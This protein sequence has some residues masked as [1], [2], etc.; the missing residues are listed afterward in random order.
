MER[1]LGKIRND[2]N[3]KDLVRHSGLLYISGLFS[4]GFMFAQQMTTASLLGATDFGRLAVVLSTGLTV[5]TLLDFRT[6]EIGSKLLTEALQSQQ[7]RETVRI[8]TWLYLVDFFAGLIG[9]A[10]LFVLAE[11]VAIS[12]LH[13]PELVWLIRLY[14]LSVPFRLLGGGIVGALP[15]YFN[16]FDWLAI[17]AVIYAVVRLVLMTGAALLGFGFTGVV[18]AA[19]LSEIVH[20]GMLLIMARAIWWNR[21]RQSAIFDLGKPT[22]FDEG[23]RMLPRFWI[24]STL[25]GLHLNLFIPIA[26][27]LTTPAQIGV[28][29]VGVAVMEL[30][31]RAIQPLWVVFTPKIIM[32]YRPS[33]LPDFRKYL[34]QAAGVS[35]V[36]VISLTLMLIIAA[37]FVLPVLLRGSEY[38]G[39][40]I[41]TIILAA[42][43]GVYMGLMWTRPA[44]ITTGLISWH[45]VLTF[46]LLILSLV[47]LVSFVPSNGAVGAAVAKAVFLAL[48]GI[49]SLL[50]LRSRVQL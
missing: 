46:A 38:E 45:N 32:L 35:G 18:I 28:F 48:S 36:V 4:L 16:H 29:S 12:L 7:H 11:F 1:I 37:P 39:V 47:V 34:R 10:L 23:R 14:A 5:A 33:T 22:N 43:N 42:A 15:R 2:A 20:V 24:N 3:L 6:W 49:G 41:V 8:I 13:D 25:I 19:L 9:V 21:L 50:L 17:K 31:D 40:V 26:A 44:I 27:L 30:I